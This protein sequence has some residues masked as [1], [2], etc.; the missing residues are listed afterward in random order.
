MAVASQLICQ[1]GRAAAKTAK[2]A[3]V[4]N[5]M[6]KKDFYFPYFF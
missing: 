5:L 6:P 1:N 3:D 2:M 4:A